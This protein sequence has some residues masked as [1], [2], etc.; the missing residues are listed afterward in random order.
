MGSD[1]L[2]RR[3]HAVRSAAQHSPWNSAL[4]PLPQFTSIA[5]SE[6]RLPAR[7]DTTC[8]SVVRGF[9]QE[10]KQQRRSAGAAGCDC[11]LVCFSVRCFL[12]CEVGAVIGGSMGR[13]R[14]R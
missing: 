11:F 2:A 4:P 13:S 10:S 7:T 8:R 14:T 3:A 1:L 12:G 5:P 6:G 9:P